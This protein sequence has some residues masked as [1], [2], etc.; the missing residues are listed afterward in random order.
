MIKK[1][2]YPQTLVCYD[3]GGK[4]QLH[5]DEYKT[6]NTDGNEVVICGKPFYKCDCGKILLTVEMCKCLDKLI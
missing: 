6:L 1:F 4:F 5:Y 3:C 2:K